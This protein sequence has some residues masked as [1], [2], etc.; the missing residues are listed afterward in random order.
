L[1]NI[2]RMHL[3]SGHQSKFPRRVETQ[4][5]TNNNGGKGTN[6]QGQL[7]CH[8][9][10]HL[11]GKG[12]SKKRNYYKFLL[13][14]ILLIVTLFSPCIYGLY[15]IFGFHLLVIRTILR[16]W[17]FHLVWKQPRPRDFLEETN[18]RFKEWFTSFF[19]LLSKYAISWRS[20]DL[21]KAILTYSQSIK[22]PSSYSLNH[23][24]SYARTHGHMI[25]FFL[26]PW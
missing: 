6:N 5:K 23:S 22:H 4:Y 12:I 10:T 9:Q 24:L 26:E 2:L 15:I 20:K 11:T 19:H 14:M 3:M 13:K 8:P 21:T 1:N 16:T 17:N 25:H 18:N 7:L